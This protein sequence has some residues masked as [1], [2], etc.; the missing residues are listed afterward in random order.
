MFGLSSLATMSKANSVLCQVIFNISENI[1][2]RVVGENQ[3]GE[4]DSQSY[5]QRLAIL[6]RL[7]NVK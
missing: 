4:G 3:H 7:W 5:T 1:D 6:A 2:Y